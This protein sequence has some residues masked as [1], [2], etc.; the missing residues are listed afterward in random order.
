MET[1]FVVWSQRG[2]NSGGRYRPGLGTLAECRLA[3]TRVFRFVTNS[4][5]CG[6]S[7]YFPRKEHY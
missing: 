7:K 6:A 3:D 5:W 4:G 2:M 1:A